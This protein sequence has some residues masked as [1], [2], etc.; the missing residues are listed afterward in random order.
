[1]STTRSRQGTEPQKPGQQTTGNGHDIA[2]LEPNLADINA[3][4]YAIFSPG[5]RQGPSRRMDRDRDRRSRRP[6]KGKTG[7]KAGKHFSVF[8]LEKAAAYAVRMNKQGRNVY[9]GMALRKGET[10]P[11][12]RATKDNVV[13]GSRGWADFDKEGDDV[14]SR[15]A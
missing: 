9:V 11:S 3:H 2:V 14:A 12:G 13:T 4:L 5:L 8:E 7:V 6:A 1:M 10:G 15:G